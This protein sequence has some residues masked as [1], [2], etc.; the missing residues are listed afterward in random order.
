MSLTAADEN[1]EQQRSAKDTYLDFI[2]L[3]TESTEKLA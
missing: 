3:E 1:S 2:V